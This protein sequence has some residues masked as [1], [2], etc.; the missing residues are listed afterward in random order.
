MTFC[1]SRVHHKEVRN[2]PSLP[3]FE[4]EMM[5]NICINVLYWV[6]IVLEEKFS[7]FPICPMERQ[8]IFFGSDDFYLRR[9]DLFSKL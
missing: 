3:P 1:R 2:R 5:V 9:D 4:R 8:T 6:V 7:T